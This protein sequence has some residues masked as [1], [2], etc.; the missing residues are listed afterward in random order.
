MK[1][2]FL[3]VGDY[4]WASS[5][6]RSY[7]PAAM[8]EDADAMQ[9]KPGG[10]IPDDYDVYI[11]M[12]TGNVSEMARLKAGGKINIVEVCDPNWWFEPEVARQIFDQC[13]A[14]VGATDAAVIDALEWYGQDI[15]S[16]VIPD[17]LHIDH[18]TE[19]RVH[20][21]VSPVRFVWYGVAANRVSLFGAVDALKRLHACGVP[22][23]LTI[24]DNM[25]EQPWGF[26]P[27]IPVYHAR[28]TIDT[29]CQI[30]AAHDI[31]LLPPYP[32]PWGK[33]KSN[34]KQLTAWACDLPVATAQDWKALYRLATDWQYRQLVA[35]DNRLELESYWHTAVTVRQWQFVLGEV[36][37]CI[38]R[39]LTAAG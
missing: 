10:Q 5:R 39:P 3:T 36:M 7:W 1:V 27:E 8:W 33:L 19:R 26:G 23:E 28:W 24:L 22:F 29:E 16:F 12:K 13:H 35:D 14:L 21:D 38:T 20:Q 34:N 37:Q 9:F 15:P 17:R 18:Y 31:A 6:Y 30:L 11:W 2:L 32:G 4:T 25:P